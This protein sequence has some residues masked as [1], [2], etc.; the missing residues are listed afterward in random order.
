M[1]LD[2]PTV[3]LLLGVVAAIVIVV[4]PFVVGRSTDAARE[5]ALKDVNKRLDAVEAHLLSTSVRRMPGVPR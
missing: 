2:W 5:A 1:T 4:R 3:C